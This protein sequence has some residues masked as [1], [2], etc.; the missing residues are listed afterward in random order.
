MIVDQERVKQGVIEAINLSRKRRFK[1][2]VDVTVVLQDINIKGPEGRIREIVTLPHKPNKP[3]KICVVAT[4]DLALQARNLGLEVIDRDKLQNMSKK[5][6]KKV[7]KRCD[8]VLVQTDL[9]G[10]AGR[11]LGPALGPRGK[12][13]VPVPATANLKAIVDKFERS[14]MVRVK[15]QPQI[16]CRVGTEDMEPDK[17]ADNVMAVLSTLEQKL[18]NPNTQIAKVII[19]TTMGPPVIVY[20]R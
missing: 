2:S 15:N 6:A 10:L 3:V 1:Q 13:P 14:V 18:P 4:G 9:M 20:S 8:W 5:E 7:A 19:K 12:I 11:I 16:M 17:I